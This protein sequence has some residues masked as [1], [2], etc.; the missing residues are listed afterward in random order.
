MGGRFG[1]AY[2]VF[3]TVDKYFQGRKDRY[4]E[5]CQVDYGRVVGGC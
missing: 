4:G 1:N 5:R 2:R 3:L